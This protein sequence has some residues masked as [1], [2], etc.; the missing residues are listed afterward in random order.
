MLSGATGGTGLDVRGRVVDFSDFRWIGSLRRGLSLRSFHFLWGSRQTP[1]APFSFLEDFTVYVA[2]LKRRKYRGKHAPEVSTPQDAFTFLKPRVQ[3]WNREHFLAVLLDARNRIIGIETVSIGSLT[4][5]IVHPRE[6]F[7]PALIASA[8]SVV[9]GHNHPSGD[10]EPSPE[11]L[12]VT[13]RLAD[14]G[15]LLGIEVLD[16][17]VFTRSA[18]VSLKGQGIL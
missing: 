4:A 3:D 1:R 15:N 7:R 5:S 6:V 2:E 16:H 18:H 11:D 12:A 17:I 8:A 14:A 9:L 13:K 10:P